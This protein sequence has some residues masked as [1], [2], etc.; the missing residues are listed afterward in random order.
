MPWAFCFTRSA[1]STSVP[2]RNNL[3]NSEICYGNRFS[4]SSRHRNLMTAWCDNMPIPYPQ[5]EKFG[6]YPRT[7]PKLCCQVQSIPSG[8]HQ[9]RLYSAICFSSIDIAP[10]P[11]L[12]PFSHWFGVADRTC[13][14]TVECLF[15]RPMHA[16][17][18]H[19]IRSGLMGPELGHSDNSLA[20]P[21]DGNDSG[22]R[23]SY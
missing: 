16:Y 3:P 5:S 4:K 1:T 12:A 13:R 7:E 2:A 15:I 11:V 9:L 21:P 17:S 20:F 8:K 14:V 22:G 18:R 23:F 19:S 6:H 10:S